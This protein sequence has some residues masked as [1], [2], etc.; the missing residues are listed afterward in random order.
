LKKKMPLV[1]AAFAVLL[2]AGFYYGPKLMS[3]QKE[4]FEQLVA[5]P[6]ADIDLS[7]IEDGTYFGSYS[8][9]PVSAKVEVIVEDH[10]IK[11]IRLL[12]HDNKQGLEAEVIPD[13]VVDSQTLSVETVSGA[14]YSS[15]V[16]LKAIENAL[17][18]ES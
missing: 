6:L 15:K 11:A 7:A 2:F 1:L 8:V 9:Y 12:K 17:L 3:A 14:T 4:T 10:H 5:A 13:R 16:I 18:G